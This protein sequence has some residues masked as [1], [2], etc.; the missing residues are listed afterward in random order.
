MEEIFN[1][2]GILDATAQIWKI[3]IR[4]ACAIFAGFLIG[5]ESRSRLKDAGVKTHTLLCLTASL[6]M[7]I[8]KYAFY[9]L[10][11][12]EG[13]QYD[14]SRVA[15]TIIS[16]LCFIGAGM[17]FYKQNNIKGLTTAVSLCLTIAIGMCFGS[18]MLVTGAII[19]LTDISLQFILH[20][21][22]GI[23]RSKKLIIVSAKFYAEDGYIDKFKQI[24]GISHFV[25]FK[26]YKQN[27][28][29]IV[30]VEFFYKVRISSEELFDIM[31]NEPQIIM[32]EKN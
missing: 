32:L 27:E 12:F 24:F 14:A 20:Q 5:F 31:Q 23:F 13:I 30:E 17:V 16:G 1:S 4:F 9:E 19:T 21:D 29:S 10:S 22:K 25:T 28:K 8:S 18:G 6:L 3:L 2:I 11:K 7:V 26:I 15:S